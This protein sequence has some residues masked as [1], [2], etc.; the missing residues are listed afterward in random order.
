M[1]RVVVAA[2]AGTL[3]EFYDFFLF[4]SLA[5]I[6][7]AHFFGD[8]AGLAATL[9]VL[10]TFGVGFAVRPFGALLFGRLGDGAGRKR[11]FSATLLLMGGAT[12]AM[13]LLP[14]RAAIGIAAPVLLVLLRLLQGLAIGGEY[15]GAAVFVAE[16]APPERRGFYTSIIQAA[17]PL[18]LLASIAVVLGVRAMLGEAA[19]ASWGWRL[20]CLLSLVLVAISLRV[21]RSLRESPV[22]TAMRARGDL[23][24]A[25][26]REALG[27]RAQWQS[28]LLVLVAVIAGQAAITGAGQLYAPIFLQSVMHVPP[29]TALACVAI[30]LT[31]CVP[32]FV[33]AGWLSDRVGRAPLLIL[34]NALG[35]L[36]IVPLFKV[37]AAASAP[38]QPVI[39]TAAI[40]GLAFLATLSFGPVAAFLVERFPAR[41]RYTSLS[42]VYHLGNGW[43][44]GFLPL[45]ATAL[46]ARTGDPVAGAWFPT[47]LCAVSA[48]VG[49]RLLRDAPKES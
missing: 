33:V 8:D 9:R 36:T 2:A 39:L 31:G 40:F 42:F 6:L 27:D 35:A 13:G 22:F 43:I 29:A 34:G 47:S 16:H 17:A 18:G 14:D 41:V 49:L 44:G 20:P 10:A 46:V 28:L 15:G 4:G 7:A 25:P 1:R 5:P 38:P 24:R 32:F 3:I 12:A 26:V 23:S 30:G 45:V 21:R 19:Y 37:M 11:A 48:V